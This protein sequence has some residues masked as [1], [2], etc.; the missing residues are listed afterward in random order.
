MAMFRNPTPGQITD[1]TSLQRGNA[2][3][4]RGKLR[5]A[6]TRKHLWVKSLTDRKA[7][8]EKLI[9][10]F[11]PRASRW[12]QLPIDNLLF[13]VER[14]VLKKLACSEE[15][16]VLEN[17]DKVALITWDGEESRK[18]KVIR[19]NNED[20]ILRSAITRISKSNRRRDELCARK[21]D[22]GLMML[23]LVLYLLDIATDCNVAYKHFSQ[24]NY[25][26]F[27]LTL[28]FILGPMLAEI[29][30]NILNKRRGYFRTWKEVFGLDSLSILPRAWR[31]M[32][33]AINSRREFD[34]DLCTLYEELNR[35]RGDYSEDQR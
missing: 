19:Q 25:L 35:L 22:A 21:V 31:S 23:C 10:A 28:L 16:N 17:L 9:N 13:G 8:E 2:V 34:Q 4:Q 32:T 14:D 33:Y 18:E 29:F 11:G 26:Y 24:S 27:A 1:N 3:F 12:S 20:L 7:L 6:L 5:D 30:R 15:K